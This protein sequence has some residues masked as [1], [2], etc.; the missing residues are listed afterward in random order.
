MTG[1]AT[2]AAGGKP[3]VIII[4]ALG[5]VVGPALSGFGFASLGVN[6]P[7]QIGAAVMLP[8]VLVALATRR[9]ANNADQVSKLD[10]PSADN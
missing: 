8:C 6:S 9:R 2:R 1:R 7:F 3:T 10:A 4:G 5:R